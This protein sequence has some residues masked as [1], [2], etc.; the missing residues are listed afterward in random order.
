MV[1]GAARLLAQ[2]GLQATSF[3]E[4]LAATD[5]PRGSIYHHFPNGKDQLIAAALK[6]ATEQMAKVLD[7]KPDTRADEVTAIFLQV[8]RT[9]LTRSKLE[10]GCAVVAVTV[11]T[12]STELLE[13][14]GRIFRGW[15]ARLAELLINGG[16]AASDAA[17]FAA[18]LVSASEGAVVLSRGERS[19]EPFELV[20]EQLTQQVRELL[21][22]R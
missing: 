2:R 13:Q 9:I 18:L 7:V 3:S 11:A 1:F 6:L 8:W 22:K 19:L 21:Q 16:L 12:E 17:R 20:A 4:V 5:A 15:R 14:V 10:A